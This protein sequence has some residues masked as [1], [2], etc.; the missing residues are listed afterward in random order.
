M[1]KDKR[2]SF[3]VCALVVCCGLRADTDWVLVLDRS[4]SMTQN[5]PYD[6]RFDA[7]KIMA[8]LL[9][10]GAE[11]TPRLTTT[12][13]AAPPET[14]LE[15]VAI[16]PENLSSIKKTIAEDPPKGDTDI[17]AALA[18]ARKGGEPAGRASDVHIILLSDGI[19]AGRN[20]NLTGRLEDEK[21]AYRDIGVAIHT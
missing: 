10:Q 1:K 17:G 18:L 6:S 16:R 21:R 20:S 3:L 13:F 7:Q 4:E 8:D 12:P 11:E 15:R 14:V 5:D 9:A 2:A 19:Q